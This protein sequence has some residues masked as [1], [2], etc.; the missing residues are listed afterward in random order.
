MPSRRDPLRKSEKNV[1]IDVEET[2]V[3][4]GLKLV[5]GAA[6]AVAGYVVVEVM[7]PMAIDH[8]AMR[9]QNAAI[10]KRLERLEIRVDRHGDNHSR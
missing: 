10:L 8:A 5:V 7:I 6:I 1:E 9:E 4:G 2:K 3:K